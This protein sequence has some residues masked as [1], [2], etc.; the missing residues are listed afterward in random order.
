[1]HDSRLF[2][3][4][5]GVEDWHGPSYAGKERDPQIA[6]IAS[7]NVGKSSGETCAGREPQS[8]RPPDAK[9]FT[10]FSVFYHDAL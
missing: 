10:D 1:M 6:R 9:G 3:E 7:L 8:L 4:R 2:K 5:R